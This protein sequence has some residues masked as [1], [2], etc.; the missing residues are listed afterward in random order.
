MS[1]QFALA[2]TLVKMYGYHTESFIYVGNCSTGWA[3]D[4]VKFIVSFI[5]RNTK[6]KW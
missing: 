1:D 3:N 4:W 2:C 6:K 5:S